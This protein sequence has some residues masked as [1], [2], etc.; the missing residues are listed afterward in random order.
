MD[1][2]NA[3]IREIEH[4][5]SK[6]LDGLITLLDP[7]FMLPKAGV[8]RPGIMSLKGGCSERDAH[9]N[10]T[11][12]EECRDWDEIEKELKPDGKSKLIRL[13]VDYFAV[14]PRDCKRKDDAGRILELYADPDGK[15]RSFPVVV[16]TMNGGT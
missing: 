8:I 7:R 12:V 4:A 14:H 2:T 5:D 16:P 10:E 11:M 6:T 13:N 3:V 1:N 15:L 9:I